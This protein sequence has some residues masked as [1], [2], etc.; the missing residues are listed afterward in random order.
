MGKNII[1]ICNFQVSFLKNIEHFRITKTIY[2]IC[3]F[4]YI[5]KQYAPTHPLICMIANSRVVGIHNTIEQVLTF[6]DELDTNFFF[7][8]Q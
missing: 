8:L 2:S 5:Y 7:L 6:Q 1:S 3:N 4:T